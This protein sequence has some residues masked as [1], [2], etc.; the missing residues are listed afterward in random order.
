M[1]RTGSAERRRPASRGDSRGARR[2]AFVLALLLAASATARAEGEVFVV[3]PESS[4]VRVHLSRAGL[5]KF[6]GH[7]HEIDAPLSGGRIVAD[8]ADPARSHVELRWEAAALAVVPGTEPEKDVPEVEERMRGPEVLDTERHPAILFTS[9]GVRIEGS[10]GDG[11]RLRVRGTLQLKG[12][13]HDVEIPLVVRRQAD[14]LSARG[15]AKLRLRD[16]GIR[17]PSVAGVVKVGNDF[18]IA[19]E[20]VARRDA[21]RP[22]EPALG[23]PTSPPL[24]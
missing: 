13:R 16:L 7:D 19:F 11:W 4:R 12:T 23:L 8:A 17:P 20:V 18:R 22:D 24:P 15:E 10:G 1:S 21:P 2:A 3:D 6:L 5:L 14:E 9:S